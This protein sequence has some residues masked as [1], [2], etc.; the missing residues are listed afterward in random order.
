MKPPLAPRPVLTAGVKS[1]TDSRSYFLLLGN[2]TCVRSRE[3]I[4]EGSQLHWTDRVLCDGTVYLTLDRSGLWTAHVPQAQA[5][6]ELWDQE[7]LRTRAEGVRLQEG[8]IKLMRA[9]SLSVEQPGRLCALPA[10]NGTESCDTDTRSSW[11]KYLLAAGIGMVHIH[12]L[13]PFFSPS[14]F[15]VLRKLIDVECSPRPRDFFASVSDPGL[16]TPGP[17]GTN[18]HQSPS[19]QKAR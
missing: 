17:H 14:G 9:L 5:L 6:K 7:V 19:L 1:Q 4:L 18:L 13:L 11:V 10:A 2:H 16:G 15:V 3:C 12:E 8:C